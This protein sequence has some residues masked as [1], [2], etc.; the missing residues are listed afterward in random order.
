MFCT[1]NNTLA[2]IGLP[3]V[4]GLL[5]NGQWA[6][7]QTILR[8]KFK[9]GEKLNYEADDKTK[10]AMTVGGQNIDMDIT[11]TIGMA[12]EIK[13]VG[14]DGKTRMS[15]KFDRVRFSMSGLPGGGKMEF[16]SKDGKVPEGP[17]GQMIGPMLKALA[18]AEF[19][20][21]MDPQGKISDLKVPQKLAESFKSLP[22]GG[23]AGGMMTEEGLKHMI[24]QASLILPS[25]AVTTGK[26]WDYKSE[27]KMPSGGPKM[28]VDNQCTYDGPA[29][30]NGKKLEKITMKPKISMEADENAPFKVK[31]KNSDTKAEACF[32][33]EAG[34]LDHMSMSQKMEME[35]SAGGMDFSQ[36]VDHTV[37]MKLLDKGK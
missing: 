21:T 15:Q 36:K 25:E 16:D 13:S 32:D 22:G 11:Q 35:I 33:N 23:A 6:S 5:I 3:L 9:Q 12:W 18:S 2:R 4:V 27:M 8:Y 30:V 1:N 14:K 7:A 34:C 29:T 37:T 24:E 19:E 17:V 10:M 20:L 28:K 31:L 26:T